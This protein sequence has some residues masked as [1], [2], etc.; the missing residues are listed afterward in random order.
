[1]VKKFIETFRFSKRPIVQCPICNKSLK[2]YML[3]YHMRHKHKYD[4]CVHC[5]KQIGEK[6]MNLHVEL[7]HS[8]GETLICK[9][10]DN[11]YRSTG[12]DQPHMWT[13]SCKQFKCPI[14]TCKDG[15]D[16][17]PELTKHKSDHHSAEL[18]VLCDYCGKVYKHRYGLRKHIR[19]FHLPKPEGQDKMWI[20]EQCGKQ[21]KSS[22]NLRCHMYRH[23]PTTR[24][25]C[26]VCNKLIRKQAFRYHMKLHEGFR[27]RCKY[28]SK[29]FKRKKNLTYHEEK[30]EG[31]NINRTCVLCKRQCASAASLALHMEK[32]EQGEKF[33]LPL[34][35]QPVTC[36]ICKKT[37]TKRFTL[38]THLK[39]HEKK[40]H[41]S[42][43]NTSKKRFSDKDSCYTCLLRFSSEEA[44]EKHKQQ[45]TSQLDIQLA[46]ANLYAKATSFKYQCQYCP[47]IFVKMDYWRDHESAVHEGVRKYVCPFCNNSYRYFADLYTHKR[48][49]K[50]KLQ[51]AEISIEVIT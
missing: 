20:C 3:N 22:L 39:T 32:H 41:S 49:C 10:C 11:E 45:H 30:H 1:M 7:E 6:H 23:K 38:R 26:H 12:K 37:V 33:D 46:E 47:K 44:L 8:G 36:P 14:Q 48:K 28:C 19:N 51:S 24:V 5:N 27:L 34:F 40:S 29:E 25:E 4:S 35:M 2:D 9:Y 13:R 50:V 18:S 42:E 31:L 17:Q 15:F 16:S 43:N 21:F